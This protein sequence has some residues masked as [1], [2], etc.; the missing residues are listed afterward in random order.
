MQAFDPSQVYGPVFSQ[1]EGYR[2]RSPQEEQERLVLL[3][4]LDTFPNLLTRE[5]P[6]AHLTS[7]SWI[8]NR[9][10][11]RVLMVYHNI[12]QSW[13]WTGGHADGDPDLLAVAVREAQEETGVQ[14]LSP[15]SREAASLDVLPVWG[16]FKRGKYVVPHLH[17]NLTYFLETDDSI[18]LHC[19]PDE[20]SGVNWFSPEKAVEACA[21]RDMKPVYEKLNEILNSRYR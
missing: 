1:I 9:A 15:L 16:H 10:H 12:Y 3:Q 19:K 18:P 11:D 4:Y 14:S 13:S 21:E 7:S 8:L 6:F 2:P 17:L 5:N 20:N